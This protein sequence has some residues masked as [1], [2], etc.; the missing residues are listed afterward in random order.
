MVGNGLSGIFIGIFRAIT[1]LIY[2]SLE[3]EYKGARMYFLLSS[4]F[5]VAGGLSQFYAR[6]SDFINYY[7]KKAHKAMNETE[8]RKTLSGDEHEL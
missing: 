8:R 1:L 2:P 3:D 7:V 5:L 6:K 4:L